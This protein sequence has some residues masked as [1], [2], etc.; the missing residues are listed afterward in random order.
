MRKARVTYESTD[1]WVFA[2]DLD[3]HV[4]VF[5]HLKHSADSRYLHVDDYIEY[6]RVESTRHPG[7]FEAHNFHY[8][9][10]RVARQISAGKAAEEAAISFQPKSN[11]ASTANITSRGEDVRTSA[12]AIITRRGTNSD[13]EGGAK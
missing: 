10:H 4:S 13:D 8:T 3:D 11:L 9:G 6:E 2:E 7:K 1:A 12:P 5:A